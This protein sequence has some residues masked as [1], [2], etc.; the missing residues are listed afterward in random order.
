MAAQ[1]A[2]PQQTA[3]NQAQQL[4]QANLSAR[5]M[6]L[7]QGYPM[8]QSIYSNVL[9]PAAQPQKTERPARRCERPHHPARRRPR[10][11]HQGKAGPA[12]NTT[13]RSRPL[14]RN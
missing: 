9:Q 6:V 8:L 14:T 3:A 11:E 10:V 13:Q 1:S 2:S 5:Q 7:S 4:Q 12:R